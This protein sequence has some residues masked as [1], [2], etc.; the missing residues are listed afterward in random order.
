MFTDIKQLLPLDYTAAI[1]GAASPSAL[2]VFATMADLGGVATDLPSVLTAGDT[3]NSGQNI[4]LLNGVFDIQNAAATSKLQ[5]SAGATEHLI[6]ATGAGSNIYSIRLKPYGVVCSV[7]IEGS[8]AVARAGFKVANNGFY[9][10]FAMT[11]AAAD[12]T[13]TFQEVSGTVAFLSDIPATPTT[14][15]SGDGTVGAGRVVTLTDSI[16]FNGGLF[17]INTVPICALQ[18]S[19]TFAAAGVYNTDYDPTV[20]ISRTYDPTINLNGHGFVEAS[21]FQRN[22][23]NFAQAAYTDNTQYIGTADYNHHGGY[24]TQFQFN[25]SGTMNNYYGFVDIPQFNSGTTNFRYGFYAFDRTGAGAVGTQFG[26]YVTDLVNA[27]ANWGIYVNTN[28]VYFGG[29]IYGRDN[30]VYAM[31]N[32]GF[33]I[34]TNNTIAE[35]SYYSPYYT[36]ARRKTASIQSVYNAAG[37]TDI[38]FNSLNKDDVTSMLER[39]RIDNLGNINTVLGKYNYMSASQTSDTIGDVRTYATYVA[40]V[41]TYFI[42]KC[43]VANATK[44]GGTWVLINSFSL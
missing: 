25:G 37:G 4:H 16:A 12:R 17:G 35:L 2:N 22:T 32:N 36:A 20:V 42:E 38:L 24:Q 29:D 41:S 14:I 11:A 19:T 21:I 40:T 39:V 13:Y 30:I 6:Q 8:P 28:N 10:I 26:L 15:Y 43:T 33:G 9:N 44:G 1:F 34:V 31:V 27:T 3:A 5:F 7:I 18:I 23:N